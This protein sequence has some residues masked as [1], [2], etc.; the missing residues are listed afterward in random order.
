MSAYDDDVTPTRPR[1]PSVTSESSNGNGHDARAEKGGTTLRESLGERIDRV[2]LEQAG[3]IGSLAQDAALARVA[4][5]KL[6]A[7]V[8]VIRHEQQRQGEVLS[9]QS[10]RLDALAADVRGIA[11]ATGAKRSISSGEVRLSLP[12]VEPIQ[13]KTSPSPTGTHFR[14]D[15][16]E[17]ERLSRVIAEREAE[18]RGAREALAEARAEADRIEAQAKGRRERMHLVIACIGTVI[19]IASLLAAQHVS[20]H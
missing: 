18:E 5:E 9:S 12:P 2:Q 16:E 7:N 10:S 4:H 1:M 14:I 15:A 8:D 20:F 17:L 11:K 3:Y 13:I 6:E 19:A